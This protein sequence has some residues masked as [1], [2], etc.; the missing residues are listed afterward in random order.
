MTSLEQRADLPARERKASDAPPDRG[1]PL[2]EL[3][4]IDSPVL[5]RR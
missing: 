1:S 4:V 3:S 2:A 5:G